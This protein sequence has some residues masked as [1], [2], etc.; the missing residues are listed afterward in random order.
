MDTKVCR[1]CGIEKQ[2][3]RFIQPSLWRCKDCEN[4]WLREHRRRKRE[5]FLLAYPKP[6]RI[7]KICKVCN[8]DK[9]FDQFYFADRKNG[10]LSSYC[11][12]CQ[13]K[14]GNIQRIRPN[15]SQRERCS[16]L[17][18]EVQWFFDQQIRQG[19]KCAICKQ[20]ESQLTKPDGK[21]RA[22]AIDHDHKT[23]AVRG[24]L[25]FRCNTALHQM[26]KHGKEWAARAVGY[27]ERYEK[28]T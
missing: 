11:K 1:E 10:V 17:K 20:P 24:L 26:E 15:R 5:A 18:V 8:E 27:L 9:P 2:L 14:I 21:I 28:E 25:C 23:N 13:I 3:Q 6:I 16:K 22:L 19:N 12:P 4:A 7:S